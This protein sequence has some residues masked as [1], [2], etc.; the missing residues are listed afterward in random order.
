[1]RNEWNH[2]SE[3][4]MAANPHETLGGIIDSVINSSEWFIVFNHPDLPLIDGLS[5][6]AEA[7]EIFEKVIAEIA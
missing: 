7:F 1:M 5:S 4:G 3:A 6:K 2:L